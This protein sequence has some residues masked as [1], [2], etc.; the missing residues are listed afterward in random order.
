MARMYILFWKFPFWISSHLCICINYLD[1]S[2]K[3]LLESGRH[4][5]ILDTA[6]I[7]YDDFMSGLFLYPPFLLS[8]SCSSIWYLS[9]PSFCGG[10]PV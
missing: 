4:D 8:L 6:L 1:N 10:E 2:V 9:D 3:L 7:T 5:E